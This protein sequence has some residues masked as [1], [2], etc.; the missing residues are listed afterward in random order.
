MIATMICLACA[1]LIAPA[2]RSRRRFVQL[3][4]AVR[5]V[6]KPQRDTI[7]RGSSGVGVALLAVLGV[8]PLVAGVLVAATVGIRVRRAR[9]DRRHGSEC[10]N[11]LDAVEAVI[12]ELRVGAH[13]SAAA[14]VAARESRG[15][16][17][18]AFAVC[19]ARSRLGGSGADGLQNPDAVVAA[20]LNGLA[21][22]WRVADYHGLA[23]AEL[24]SASRADLL[25]R[26]RFRGRTAAALAGARA[27]ATVLA[28]LPLLGIA[29]GQLMGAAPLAVLF[30]SSA[31]TVLLPLGAGLGCVGLLWTDAI[32]RKVVI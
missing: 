19:A 14:A 11:L 3:F 22:A 6:R 10:A 12:G 15:E 5:D 8:G 32:T 25:G 9:R 17:A 18:Q 4:G 31:G 24:L 30:T 13:P 23:L 21:D 2:S 28:A 20:E 7:I 16:A 1:L 29:L 27:T 26:I